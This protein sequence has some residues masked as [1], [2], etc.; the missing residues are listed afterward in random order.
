MN[1]TN[2]HSFNDAW[3]ALSELLGLSQQQLIIGGI[4]VVSVM[5]LSAFY[6]NQRKTRRLSQKLE[7][8]QH[9]LLVANN[10]AIGMGQQLL[11]LEKKLFTPQQP[12]VKKPTTNPSTVKTS[13]SQPANL[14]VVD[15]NIHS[16]D[17]IPSDAVYEQSRQLLAQ[18]NTI[19]EVSKQS[20][21]SYSE[22]SLMKKMAQ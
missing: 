5:V 14:T 4:G 7:R 3:L 1:L 16:H 6:I 17:S 2:I 8:L 11:S 22:V 20:G 12:T 9:D 10:S 21:L 19:E 13:R 15:N 18:G